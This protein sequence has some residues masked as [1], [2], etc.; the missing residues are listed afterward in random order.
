QHHA[1]LRAA[2]LDREVAMPGRRAREVRDLA[3]N[4]DVAVTKE[5]KVDL[6]DQLA[7]FPNLWRHSGSLP[8][9][10]R[11][12][13]CCS[14][15]SRMAQ[16]KGVEEMKAHTLFTKTAAGLGS[17]A[18]ALALSACSHT[19]SV[20]QTTGQQT[21]EIRTEQPAQQQAP[22]GKTLG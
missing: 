12:G 19:N 14:T 2:I 22:S 6:T 8:I 18:L 17:V 13:H 15:F 9:K 4:G 1:Q 11:Q 21:G 7:D 3:F 10:I 20:A 5:I 16:I